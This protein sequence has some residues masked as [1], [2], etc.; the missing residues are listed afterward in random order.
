MDD[1]FP[2]LIVTQKTG[3]EPFHMA[4]QPTSHRLLQFWQWTASDLASNAWRGLLAEFIVGEALG[5]TTGV[6]AEW[7]AVD[8]DAVGSGLAPCAHG[9]R[10]DPKF[11]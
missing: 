6:R 1:I 5:L 7:D 4:G 9:A 8:L 3:A 2:A 11:H 10:P